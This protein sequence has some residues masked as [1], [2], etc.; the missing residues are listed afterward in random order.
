MPFQDKSSFIVML[1]KI[2][3]LFKRECCV[4][5]SLSLVE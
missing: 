1:D 2:N 3:L 5:P 4:S